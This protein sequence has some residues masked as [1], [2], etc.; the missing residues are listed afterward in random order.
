MKFTKGIFAS[1]LVFAFVFAAASTASAY[2]HMGTLKMGSTGSQ[3]ME[4]QKALNAKG[5]V[6]S[7]TGAGSVG[8]ESTYFGAK[9]KTAVMA[10]QSANML[11]ADGVV[12]AM[13]GA[14]LASAVVVPGPGSSTGSLCPNGMTLASNCTMA[15]GSTTPTTPSGPLAGTDGSINDVNEISSYNNEEIGEGRN[16]VKVLGFEV[17]A[18][19]D[20][21][22]AIKSAKVSVTIT[23]ASGSD[24]LDD[25]VDSVSVWMGSTKVGSADAG[26]FSEGSSGVWTKTVTLSNPVVKADDTE[27]FYISVDAAGSFDSGDIDSES[28]TFDV[29]NL[30]FVDGS[31]VVTT[32][33]AYDLGSMDVV[34]DFVSFSTSA[35]IE[36][37]ISTA[38]D[39]PEAGVV[40]VDDST[41]TD[42]VVL[43]KG[44]LK[45]EG[46]S[47]VNIDEF[48]VSFS[49][50]GANINVI[51]ES[52][53]LVI[54]GEEYTESVPSIADGATGSVTFDNLDF[55]L[56][57]GDTVT[58]EVRADM[59]D[60]DGTIFAEGDT[61]EAN[62]TSDNRDVM[63]VENE[64]GD[65][66]SDSSEKSGTAN[67]DAQEFRTEGISLTLVSTSSSVTAG[68]STSD[69]LGEFTIKFKVKANG[70]S[71]YVSSLAAAS[72]TTTGT[73]AIAGVERSGT[74][75]IGGVSVTIVND[76]DDDL[77]SYGNFLIEDG[78]EE[79]FIMTT[80]VQLPTAGS[81]GQYRALLRALD[82]STSDG[83]MSGAGY[84]SNLDSFKTSYKALN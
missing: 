6:V 3:V 59:T 11:T 18:T 33:D 62:V 73:G 1:F 65:Q 72:L 15:P 8:M 55:D 4:L 25:Y 49:P 13:T 46:D 22:I 28:A 74:A 32:E 77:T 76:T 66:L 54:D 57:A 36:L 23:N 2:T 80:T 63:D 21:D 39:S 81:A 75:T 14:K 84:I 83:A 71:V 69:D 50:V 17:E 70:S 35:D 45:L 7:T 79:T 48:P 40:M 19:N 51:A 53:K 56:S 27:K 37:V 26:D 52:L 31:G 10:F 58:F 41:S 61:L 9:T 20:G 47:D 29:D 42:D 68:N 67:G 30:K 24:N 5:F 64:E 12:G 16:D 44:K 60:M 82:W 43:L 38:S 34:A 78:D